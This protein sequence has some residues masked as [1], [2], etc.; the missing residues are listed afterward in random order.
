MPWC[1]IQYGLLLF[2]SGLRQTILLVEGRHPA[3]KEFSKHNE[4]VDLDDVHT[5]EFFI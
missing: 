3:G 1:S 2:Y 5:T 4:N